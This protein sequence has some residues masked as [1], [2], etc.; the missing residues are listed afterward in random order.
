MHSQ[1]ALLTRIA[2][3]LERI[4]TRLETL[5]MWSEP[6]PDPSLEPSPCLHPASSRLQMGPDGIF[7]EACQRYVLATTTPDR[8]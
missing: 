3:A 1:N 5:E 7:C 8:P 4:A 2:L 6:M